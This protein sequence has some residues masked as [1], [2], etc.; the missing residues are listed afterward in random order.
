M[1]VTVAKYIFWNMAILCFHQPS[2]VIASYFSEDHLK[3]ISYNF[4]EKLSV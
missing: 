1:E 3:C 2:Y 4:Q